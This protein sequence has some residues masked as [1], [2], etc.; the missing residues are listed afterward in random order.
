ME[1]DKNWANLPADILIAIV[2][3]LS[4]LHDFTGLTAVCKSWN[5][6]TKDYKPLLPPKYP[7]LLLAEDVVPGS[8]ISD[9]EF[10]SDSSYSTDNLRR[11]YKIE[12][13]EAAG[14]LILGANYGWLLTLG[15]DLQIHLLHP[16]LRYQI[17]LP[18]MLTFPAQYRNGTPQER[19]DMFIHKVAM[20]SKVATKDAVNLLHDTR[21]LTPPPIVMVCYGGCGFHSLAYCRFGDKEWTGV[22]IQSRPT[23]D[24]VYHK[25]RF[26]TVNN[27]GE[28]FVC[29]IQNGCERP[30]AT[31]IAS[32][33]FET[34]QD[35]KYLVESVS[36]STLF[37][38]VHCCKYKIFYPLPRRSKYRTT[39][40]LVWKM[41][42]QD[43]DDCLEIPSCTLTKENNIGNQAIF[44]G[45][46]TSVSISPS[47]TVRPNCIYFTDDRTDCYHRVGGGHDMGIFSMEDRTIEPHFSGKSIHFI[48]P[49][50]WYI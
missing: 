2:E 50:L 5:S 33:P 8:I 47:E 49:P 17:P 37:L 46:N 31:K 25:G 36:G 9:G 3:R 41:E 45:R 24:I 39:N 22:E 4:C 42:I 43:C 35:R 10:D 7:L 44:V 28:V 6:G 48:S 1:G 32:L 23:D 27:G 40:F 26:Y 19:F 16:L 14:R 20:S 13:P 29:D 34:F 11:T 18:P 12:L 38:L 15:R 30:R 21:I